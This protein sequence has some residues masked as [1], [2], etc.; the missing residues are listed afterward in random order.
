MTSEAETA[1][2]DLHKKRRI[3]QLR[4]QFSPAAA[5]VAATAIACQCDVVA[6]SKSATFPCAVEVVFESLFRF[7]I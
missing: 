2:L 4:E 1:S 5:C 3:K 6:K 7:N